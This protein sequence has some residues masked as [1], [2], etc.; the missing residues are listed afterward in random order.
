M[1]QHSSFLVIAWFVPFLNHGAKASCTHTYFTCKGWMMTGQ[2]LRRMKREEEEGGAE[3]GE[4]R[5]D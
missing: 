2:E 5:G 1:T 3:R 4:A